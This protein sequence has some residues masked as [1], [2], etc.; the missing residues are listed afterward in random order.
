[1]LGL[2]IV[3]DVVDVAGAGF[4]EE[5]LVKHSQTLNEVVVS[6]PPSYYSFG[7]NPNVTPDVWFTPKQ[8]GAGLC[9]FWFGT[10]SLVYRARV[11]LNQC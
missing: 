7:E 1:M 2:H 6:E 10:W 3:V 11:L 8:V 5:E 4:S 9:C